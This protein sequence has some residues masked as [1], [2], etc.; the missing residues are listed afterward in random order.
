MK[1]LII[2]V[3]SK[4]ICFIT[5]VTL[6]FMIMNSRNNSKCHM[7]ISGCEAYHGQSSYIHKYHHYR[8]EPKRNIRF[9]T[10]V[11]KRNIRFKIFIR[12]RLLCYTSKLVLDSKVSL[13]VYKG[14]HPNSNPNPNLKHVQLHHSLVQ[15]SPQSVRYSLSFIGL[16]GGIDGWENKG[17]NRVLSILFLCQSLCN[18]KTFRKKK[19][20]IFDLCFSFHKGQCFNSML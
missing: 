13:M 18:I 4:G 6:L 8:N 1:I 5:F 2:V 17:I 15:P 20:K 16:N 14:K 10:F 7:V 3:T 19:S 9:E 11:P 12:V